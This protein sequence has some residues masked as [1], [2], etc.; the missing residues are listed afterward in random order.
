MFMQNPYD[1]SSPFH[2]FMTLT[3]VQQR[4]VAGINAEHRR[5]V[6]RL[7]AERGNLLTQL[8]AGLMTESTKTLVLI[9]GGGAVAFGGLLQAIWQM[10]NTD[11]LRTSLLHGVGWFATGLLLGAA[12]PVLRYFTSFDPKS[13][14]AD[15][16][17][18][19]WWWGQMAAMGA[20]AFCFAV[21]CWVAVNAGLWSV[22]SV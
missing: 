8:R 7:D 18:S 10:P 4:F 15:K 2:V 9:N 6:A 12:N 19:K 13:L 1:P 17:K 20:S 5:E 14:S 21:A 3:D 22:G 11:Y 16:R